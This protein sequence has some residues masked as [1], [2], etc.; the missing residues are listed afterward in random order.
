MVRRLLFCV[1]LLACFLGAGAQVQRVA[2]NVGPWAKC[3]RPLGFPAA[4]FNGMNAPL[5]AASLD[6]ATL[7]GYYMGDMSGLS[8]LGVSQPTT[9]WVGYYVESNDILKGGSI[10]GV[11]VPLFTTDNMTDFSV[12]I[13]K[14]LSTNDVSQDVPME[15]L[16][17]GAYNAIALDEPYAIPE[18][19]VYVGVKFTISKVVTQGDAYPVL[20]S[21]NAYD[22]SLIMKT[23]VQGTTSWGNYSASYGSFGMQLFLSGINQPAVSAHVGATT[24][25]VSLSGAEATIRALLLSNGKED[26]NSIDYNVEI[27]GT[28]TSYHKDFTPTVAGGFNSV[29]EVELTFKAPE[30]ILSYTANLNIE[31]INGIANPESNQTA[32]VNG[33]VVSRMAERKTVV[34]EF[35]GTGC[36]WCPRGWVGMETLKKEQSNFIGIA[37]HLYNTNDPMYLATYYRTDKL[38]LLG[39]PSCALDRNL[40]GLDPYYGTGRYITEDFKYCNAILPDVVV[41]VTGGFNEDSTMV[42]VK[43]DIEYLM[44]GS[45]YSVAYVLTA[46]S[47]K[48]TTTSWRQANYYADA[49]AADVDYDPMLTPFCSGGENG[50]SYVYLTFNDVM[51]GSSYSAMTFNRFT[52]A[53]TGGGENKADALTGGEKAGD[54]ETNS[55]VLSMPT[56]ST[57]KAAV[58]KDEVY[59]VALVIAEDGT[60]A[61]AARAK[62]MSYD[63]YT[64]AGIGSVKDDV[65][66][67]TEVARYTLNGVKLTAPQKGVNIVK[68]SN[69]E[70]RKVVVR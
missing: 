37:L 57:L 35:T 31:K 52:G 8:G 28:T 16:K 45:K 4:G 11:N 42:N 40:V 59:V 51:I 34:E 64:A 25:A 19:G 49:T 20:T 60:I 13:S 39:A 65:A 15:N 62:V 43:S 33:K 14:N 56:K 12:W 63:D 61:N 21:D 46:D 32:I 50:T 27:N 38:G 70:V 1:A 23:N 9:Y 17:G 5:K 22:M 18:T 29:N 7:W 41:D 58:R 44:D 3:D 6:G 26:I 10:S 55:Y 66:P 69:G 47:L 68:M 24:T 48:G 2:D 67:A 36:G 30:A 53:I 54:K